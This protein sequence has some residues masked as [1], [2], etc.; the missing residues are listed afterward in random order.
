MCFDICIFVQKTNFLS[1]YPVNA[2]VK[3]VHHIEMKNEN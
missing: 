2:C 1:T 3:T